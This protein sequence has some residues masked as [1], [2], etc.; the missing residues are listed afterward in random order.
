MN[1]L[2]KSIVLLF[3]LGIITVSCGNSPDN[4]GGEPWNKSQLLAPEKLAGMLKDPVSPNLFIF[5]IGP[6]GLIKNA[7]E[8]GSTMEEENLTKLKK[9]LISLPRE[10][11]VVIYCGCCPFTDCPNIRP[12]FSLLNEMNFSNPYLLNLPKNLKVNWIDSGYPMAE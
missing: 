1:Q 4:S 3:T 7:I 10:A 2:L 6:A 8:I 11:D 9:A 12:A 5:D